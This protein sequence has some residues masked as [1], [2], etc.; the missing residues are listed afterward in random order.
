[1]NKK[2]KQISA[3][4]KDKH[5][6]LMGNYICYCGNEFTARVYD[7]KS[8]HTTSCGCYAREVRA[9]NLRNYNLKG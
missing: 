7:I 5:R 9:N 3:F 6:N 1:M 2:I 8:G 4:F